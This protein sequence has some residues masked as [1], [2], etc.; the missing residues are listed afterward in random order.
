[1]TVKRLK[2]TALTQPTVSVVITYTLAK[3]ELC[4]D[5]GLKIRIGIK[6]H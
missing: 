2:M 4:Y 3:A 6:Y 1:M 5:V